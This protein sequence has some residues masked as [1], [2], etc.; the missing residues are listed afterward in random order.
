MP[1][2]EIFLIMPQA[3]HAA[4]GGA[5]RV[6]EV[7]SMQEIALPDRLTS[8]VRYFL[9]L[10]PDYPE[11]GGRRSLDR[12]AADDARREPVSGADAR[13]GS[14]SQHGPRS[15]RLDHGLRFGTNRGG[16]DSRPRGGN[17]SGRHDAGAPLSRVRVAV[18]ATSAM[19]DPCPQQ[20]PG[21]AAVARL[22]RRAPS[23]GSR[24]VLRVPPS[25]SRTTA[26]LPLRSREAPRH[27]DSNRCD[28]KPD[29]CHHAD[30]SANMTA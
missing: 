16:P 28:G 7:D 18:G 12:A 21:D 25:T 2:R 24:S 8:P 17:R 4:P 5:C 14:V 19:P 1:V 13:Q 26:A 3:A 6:Q 27:R 23:R 30:E 22:L 10:F 9:T 29:K 11:A 20:V 15:S